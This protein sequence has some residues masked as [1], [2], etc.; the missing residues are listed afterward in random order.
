MRPQ[1]RSTTDGAAVT[2]HCVPVETV[3]CT[4]YNYHQDLVS[5]SPSLY[6]VVYEVIQFLN[7]NIFKKMMIITNYNIQMSMK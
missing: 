2:C 6:L 5:G 7:S 1:T 4:M 3:Q